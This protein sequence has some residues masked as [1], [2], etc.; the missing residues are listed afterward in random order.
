MPTAKQFKH[1]V[2]SEVLPTIRKYDAYMTAETIEE[3]ILNPDTI[4]KIATELKNDCE[5]RM[6]AEQRNHESQPKADYCDKILANKSLVTIT[7]IA[8]DYG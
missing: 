2:T 8:K 6:I 7:Y 5:R 1:W 4:I 3:A